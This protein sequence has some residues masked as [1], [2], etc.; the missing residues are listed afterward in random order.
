MDQSEWELFAKLLEAGVRGSSESGATGLRR[1]GEGPEAEERVIVW[2][3]RSSAL[4]VRA[5]L[6]ATTPPYDGISCPDKTRVFYRR[7]V[8]RKLKGFLELQRPDLYGVWQRTPLP[9]GRLL[10]PAELAV[11]ERLLGR[12]VSELPFRGVAVIGYGSGWVQLSLRDLGERRWPAAR[13]NG[14]G[15]TLESAAKA[16]AAPA[17]EFLAD[18]ELG[19]FVQFY[20]TDGLCVADGKPPAL[21]VCVLPGDCRWT[22]FV[23]VSWELA[24]EVRGALNER[25]DVFD[26]ARLNPWRLVRAASVHF[27]RGLV[28][29]AFGAARLAV[30]LWA[31]R[32]DEQS[33]EEALLGAAEAF[34]YA[35]HRV[36][37]ELLHSLLAL[38]T[39][40]VGS[41]DGAVS[42][43]VRA[44]WF[45]ELGGLF[46]EYG[47]GE[48]A[49]EAFRILDAL[50][51]GPS[52]NDAREV[53][54]L[55]REGMV[56]AGI[57]ETTRAFERL[58]RAEEIVV[59]WR[60]S[61][62]RLNSRLSV[63]NAQAW[64]LADKGDWSGA[65]DTLL[66]F[67]EELASYLDAAA[68]GEYPGRRPNVTEWNL[69]ELAHSMALVLA[70]PET[71][72]R[73]HYMGAAIATF[74][75]SGARPQILRPGIVG[76][77]HRS[78]GLPLTMRKPLASVGRETLRPDLRA[79]A[80]RWLKQLAGA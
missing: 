57:G 30:A 58:R 29:L 33:R 4:R 42:D 21:P 67:A 28:G 36:S 34:Y 45:Q 71:E 52:G 37:Q 70:R 55:R 1:D 32:S 44:A 9:V 68:S 31:A 22:S 11:V 40:A 77:W 60:E 12:S 20:G 10:H 39:T 59:A 7:R 38:V 41:G 35:R 53:S 56:L 79:L 73:H 62:A 19:A 23:P 3:E 6:L 54:R 5:Q 72:R 76:K 50:M 14:R 61:E 51:R 74:R 64:L 2:G 75:R 66:P 69:G 46:G 80:I 25:Y 43:A 24:S 15:K 17:A 78:R 18:R 26:S 65:R 13:E 48:T 47:D 16:S 49:S 27:G 8:W 63:A